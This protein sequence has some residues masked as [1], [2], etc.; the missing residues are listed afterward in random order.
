M[1]KVFTKEVIIA[2]VTIISLVMFYVGFNYL[3]GINVFKPNNQYY[4]RMIKVPELQTSS[5]VYVDG[6]KVGLVRS[7]NYDYAD[8]TAEY[9]IVEISL[10]K[11]M[12]L[13]EGSY[14][15]LKSGLTSGA[16]LDLVLNRYVSSF[17]SPGDTISSVSNPSIMDK[18]TNDMLPQVENILPRLDSILGGIQDILTHPA[19]SNSFNHIQATTNHLSHSTAKL[20]R[21]LSGDIP[22][23]LANLKKVSSD[24]SLVGENLAQVDINAT[25]EKVD[26]TIANLEDL[27]KQL[28]NS[29]SSLGLLMNDASLYNHLDSTAKNAAEL[30][31]DLKQNPKRYV[32]F[33]VF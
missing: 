18:L 4:V 14:I 31:K 19:I 6:F 17:H 29:E 16:Y 26:K 30:L 1:K 20:D 9:I 10:D 33:S 15:E 11:K 32:H 8:P 7:I 28:S 21:M 12:K 2:I 27:T 3:K 25:M 22:E 24:L 13:Q 5:P 23:I